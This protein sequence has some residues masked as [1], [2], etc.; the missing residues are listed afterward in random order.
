MSGYFE[1]PGPEAEWRAFL[2]EGRFMIQRSASSGAAVFYPRTIAPGTGAADLE[3]VEAAGTGTV[4]AT[5]CTRQR[6][7]KGGDYNISIVEL[8]EGPRLMTR[9][10]GVAPDAVRIGMRVKARIAEVGGALNVVFDV[11]EG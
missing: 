6:P 3:W 11:V 7:E 5:T 8:D 9:V 1:G 4:H 10:D 2:A